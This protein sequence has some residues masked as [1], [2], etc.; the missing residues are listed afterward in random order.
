M[1]VDNGRSW[2]RVTQYYT[3]LNKK[4][5]NGVPVFKISNR[6]TTTPQSTM[7]TSPFLRRRDKRKQESIDLRDPFQVIALAVRFD[8]SRGDLSLLKTPL[9]AGRLYDRNQFAA[10]LDYLQRKTSPPTRIEKDEPKEKDPD[11]ALTPIILSGL[12]TAL[13][14]SDQSSDLV[15]RCQIMR[16]AAIRRLVLA[17]RRH[18][19]SS[20]VLPLICILVLL[21][22]YLR[23]VSDLRW[24]LSQLRYVKSCDDTLAYQD[25]CHFAEA[26]LWEKF[27]DHVMTLGPQTDHRALLES[28]ATE[29]PLSM[30][31][32]LRRDLLTLE[33]V[34]AQKRRPRERRLDLS[35]P[36]R[37]LGDST[38]HGLVREVVD[39]L[40][41]SN[42]T[43]LD[44]GCGVGGSLYALYPSNDKVALHYHGMA[45]SAAEIH[46]ARRL[47]EHF[48]LVANFW[49][50]SF[51]DPLPTNTYSVVL[52]LD[53]LSFADL[54]P[55]TLKNLVSSLQPGGVLIIADDVL[56]SNDDMRLTIGDT[57]MRPSLFSAAN[58]V[59]WLSEAGCS[60]QMNRDLTLEYQ[61][62]H[63]SS[64]RQASL[65]QYGLI[66]ERWLA[67]WSSNPAVRR[68]AELHADR[69]ELVEVEALRRKEY[70]RQ[71]LS[72]HMFVCVK[73]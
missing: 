1:V 68:M 11:Y 36:Y 37:W 60:V 27:R 45:I 56:A 50:G 58:W 54:V 64:K 17:Q 32:I 22:L 25:R 42:I 9:E 48:Q 19:I 59:T 5:V 28:P 55:N 41:R 73:Q 31:T 20:V 43:L 66:G 6:T 2:L 35:L 63:A 34:E 65:W 12:L 29:S 70:D 24:L 30:H 39:G 40:H 69:A 71:D 51:D 57:M 14:S 7:A 44:V 62:I 4:R 3:V 15:S 10:A 21:A 52:A 46:H 18:Q 23:S 47:A 8:E 61:R 72:Y 13:P 67:M 53:S 26:A 33:E 49:Q 38:V 16:S